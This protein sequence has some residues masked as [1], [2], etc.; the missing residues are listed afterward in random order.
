M[1]TLNISLPDS[2][3]TFV[4]EQVNKKG[5]STASEYVRHLIRQEQEREEQKQLET[6]LLNGLDS[7]DPV[8]I[9][10][11]WWANKRMELIQRLHHQKP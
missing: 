10:D 2:M 1:T 3:R 11:E 7:G 5:Y 6:L 4:N 8:E 9:N